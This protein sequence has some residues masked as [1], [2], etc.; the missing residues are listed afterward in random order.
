MGRRAMTC[1]HDHRYSF[2]ILTQPDKVFFFVFFRLKEAFTWPTRKRFTEE[3]AQKAATE[4]ADH[5]ISDTMVFGE[6][7]KKRSRGALI[8]LEEGILKH[9][10]FGRT[11]LAGD[12]V[13]KVRAS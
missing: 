9:W 6:L 2:L 10:H 7:W 8:S 3:D 13:H 1:I 11:V 12:S 4:V 5:P